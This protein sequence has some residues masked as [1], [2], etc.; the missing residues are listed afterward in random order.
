MQEN[1][2]SRA[3]ACPSRGGGSDFLLEI[4]HLGAS[5]HQT[6][7]LLMGEVGLRP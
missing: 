6:P 3:C 1:A 7:D 2:P 4:G 5:R